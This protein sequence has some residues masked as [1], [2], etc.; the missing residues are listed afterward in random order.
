MNKKSKTED[1]SE[2]RQ[3]KRYYDSTLNYIKCKLPNNDHKIAWIR[4]KGETDQQMV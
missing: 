4:L 3:K 2:D 1:S